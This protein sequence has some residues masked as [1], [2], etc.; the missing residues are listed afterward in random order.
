MMKI[1]VFDSDKQGKVNE[2]N[3]TLATAV[4]GKYIVGRSPQS[5]LIL[6]GSDVSRQ[7]G[8]FLLQNENYYY[9][10]LGSANGSLINNNL[11][12]KNQSY[13]LKSGDI[14]RIGEFFLVMEVISEETEPLVATVLNSDW[15]SFAKIDTPE[16]VA[17]QTPEPVSEVT[18]VVEASQAVSEVPEL[19]TSESE[20]LTAT[21]KLS[22]GSKVTSVHAP[23]KAESE[24]IAPTSEAVSEVYETEKTYSQE[25]TS[26]QAPEEFEEVV[27]VEA[28]TQAPERLEVAPEEEAESSQ[29]TTEIAPEI[30]SPLPQPVNQALDY[31]DE[32]AA[33]SEDITQTP[34]K[35]KKEEF[36]EV[37]MVAES[38]T[39]QVPAEAEVPEE[40]PESAQL[41]TEI[42]QTP[43]K[44]KEE[45]FAE[46]VMVAES[47]TIQVPAEAE[48]PEEEPESAQLIT[49]TTQ[50]PEKEKKEE[51]A[52][53]V[54]VAESVT[55]QV[56]AEAEVPEEEEAE[57]AQLITEIAPEQVIP[58]PEAVAPPEEAIQTSE[59]E[60]TESEVMAQP[61]KTTSKAFEIISKKYIA[62]MAHDTKKLELVQFVNQYKAFL[63]KCL[64]I[65]TPSI[66]ETLY[67]QT[68]LAVSQKTP[69]VPVGGYQATASLVGSG[70][71]LAVVLLK[72]FMVTQSNQ[73]N[74]EALLR[75][76][77]INQVLVATNMSTAEAVMHYIKDMVTSL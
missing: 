53:V 32:A 63:S 40:E 65:A 12:K 64:T 22:Q 67:K 56:P 33:V 69:L 11:A 26:V 41:I 37:V 66:S 58:A 52:E 21:E 59:E 39:I 15:Q 35:E 73:T 14:I 60:E 31:D 46:V 77:N 51:F 48:V 44:E 28:T 6:N 76:C 42:T 45:E 68:G 62:L 36:A 18:E 9:S 16:E 71:I 4:D 7:H 20:R 27:F 8:A 13:L 10:D 74:E 57:S 23:E 49:E 3:L 5:G 34:E 24:V 43:E 17:A 29:V 19:V 72:D 75:L 47:V 61:P 50:T 30:A 55:I 1:K 38:V 70:E 2:I 25:I 54:M